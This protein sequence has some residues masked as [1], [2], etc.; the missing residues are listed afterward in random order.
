[1]KKCEKCGYVRSSIPTM[2]CG[3]CLALARGETPRAPTTMTE[4]EKRVMAAFFGAMNGAVRST[5][6][7]KR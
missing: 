4:A 7:G 2:S 5:L 1:M 3:G 6:K